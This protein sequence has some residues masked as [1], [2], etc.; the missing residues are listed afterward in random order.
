MRAIRT[1][2][3]VPHPNDSRAAALERSQDD[4]VGILGDQHSAAIRR[5]LPD[6]VVRCREQIEI[7]HVLRFVSK[8][9]E[10]TR[11]LRR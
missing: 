5:L 7:G 8:L 2:R 6:T 3:V 9:D 10:S 11:K 4:E 1:R